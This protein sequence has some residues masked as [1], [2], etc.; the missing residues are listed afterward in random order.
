MSEPPSKAPK[1]MQDEVS[2][3]GVINANVHVEVNGT[4]SI[5]SE[6]SKTKSAESENTSVG[7]YNGSEVN[8]HTNGVSSSTGP[9]E[10]TPEVVGDGSILKYKKLSDKAITP[11]RGSKYA[12]GTLPC[13]CYLCCM[14]MYHC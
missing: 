12:A 2:T 14:T 5:C 9:R 11:T 13:I 10:E 1:M 3:N 8:G 4:T 7:S 6:E